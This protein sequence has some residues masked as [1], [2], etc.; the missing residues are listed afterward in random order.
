V[1]DLYV[2]HFPQKFALQHVAGTLSGAPT[3]EGSAKNPILGGVFLPRCRAE[4]LRETE[5]SC[6][7][8]PTSII[9]LFAEFRF[10]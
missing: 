6:T 9:M 7:P 2:E 8:T 1:L 4:V 3:G 5:P 10:N